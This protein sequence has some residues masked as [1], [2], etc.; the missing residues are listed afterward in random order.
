MTTIDITCGAPSHDPE[1][2]CDVEVRDVTP[3]NYSPT[4]LDH[5]D[6]V[7]KYKR[8]GA[9]WNGKKLAT[10]LEGLAVAADAKR[11]LDKIVESDTREFISAKHRRVL[12]LA[13]REAKSL[14]EA[15][16]RL[17]LTLPEAVSALSRG[18]PAPYW[19]W[20]EQDWLDFEEVIFEDDDLNVTQLGKSFGVSRQVAYRLLEAYG[21]R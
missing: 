10:L 12:S 9:P 4:D 21:V 5:A 15:A 7:I 2:L 8:L 1:C 16:V 11:E 20:T 18:R 17:D 14:V 13:M 19:K 6:L 3:I